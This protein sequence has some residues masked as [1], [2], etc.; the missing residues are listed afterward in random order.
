V[1]RD[2]VDVTER[3]LDRARL[4][5]RRRAAA[6]VDKVDRLH[7][8]GDGMTTRE[9]H[10]S[11]P[12]HHRILPRHHLVPETADGVEEEEPGGTHKRLRLGQ[13]RLRTAVFAD[14]LARPFVALVGSE[15]D[16]RVLSGRRSATPAA[17]GPARLGHAAS[18]V[19]R[20][21]S[22]GAAPVSIRTISMTRV[23]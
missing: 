23:S 10:Q 16:Q 21:G 22:S 2:G 4:V 11:P 14:R 18:K 6:E 7:G 5:Q 8:A 20:A 17:P 9:A 13:S 12:M 15:I 1:L 19:R 3:A